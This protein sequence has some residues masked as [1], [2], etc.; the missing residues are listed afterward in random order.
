MILRSS[1]SLEYLSSLAF[2]PSELAIVYTAESNQPK[3]DNPYHRFRFQ[4]DF[5]E[6]LD[7][8]KC[9]TTFVLRWK[10]S[11]FENDK[12]DTPVIALLPLS[13]PSHICLGQ[14]IFSPNSENIIYG[15]GYEY[16]RDGRMLG[17]KGCYNRPTGIWQVIIKNDPTER[18]TCT[19]QKLTP[20]HLSCR[21]PRSISSAGSSTLLWLSC[22]TGGAHV[23]TST[24]HVLDITSD[25]SPID[26]AAIEAAVD[27]IVD[28]VMNPIRNKFPGL[29][30]SYNMP[31]S[32]VVKLQSQTHILISSAWGSRF[33]ILLV[34]VKDGSVRD[35]TPASEE[36]FS[37][38]I[39]ATDGSCRFI[40]SRSSPSIPYE[41]ILGTLNDAGDVAWK[42]LDRPKLTEQGQLNY[43]LLADTTSD[44]V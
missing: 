39:L 41:V 37:W 1:F 19:L 18:I 2:S 31:Y 34:S 14:A 35:L 33:T 16:S 5:G 8:K 25:K 23:S 27:P 42:V 17:L 29:Y 24:L 26:P 32:P 15:T 7:G 10:P 4:P 11:T 9:P 43:A 38:S 30:P 3:S 36:L 13:I 20:S 22:K 28:V 44:S 6:G 40:C 12:N 21:S